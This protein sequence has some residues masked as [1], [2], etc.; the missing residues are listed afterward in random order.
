MTEPDTETQDDRPV[1]DHPH[2]SGDHSECDP[3]RCPDIPGPPPERDAITRRGVKPWRVRLRNV[4]LLHEAWSSLRFVAL[5]D[6]LRCPQCTAVGTW[7]P[8]GC[9]SAKR[10]GDRPVRRW[11]C[12]NCGRYEGP[13]GVLTVFPCPVLGVWRLPYPEDPKA[14]EDPPPTPKRRLNAAKVWPWVG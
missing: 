1:E 13:E 7:K 2:W 9:W 6:R 11:M 4:P 5:R 12:K 10:G 14:P 8:H 3:K